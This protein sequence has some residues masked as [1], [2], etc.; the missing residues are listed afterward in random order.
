MVLLDAIKS[1]V[2]GP[3]TYTFR[4]R[5]SGPSRHVTILVRNMHMHRRR[6]HRYVVTLVRFLNTGLVS[7]PWQ[8][9][10]LI[11]AERTIDFATL[12]DRDARTALG[13]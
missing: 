6:W 3:C 11:T 7:E 1:V 10:S 9:F 2:F 8:C 12:A 4:Q 13:C 5:G